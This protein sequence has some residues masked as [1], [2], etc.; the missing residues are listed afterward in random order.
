MKRGGGFT[1]I[2]L[3]VTLLI[4]TIVATLIL[5]SFRVG[6][7]SWQKGKDKLEVYQNMRVCLDWMSSKIRGAFISSRN[8]G[9]SFQAEGRRLD[10]VV[11]THEEGGLS[12]ISLWL[13][14]DLNL[15]LMREDSIFK[16]LKTSEG[17]ILAE[18]VK[19]LGFEYY[20]QE[21]ASWKGS[22]NSK[23]LRRLPRAVKIS[24]S[25]ILEGREEITLLPV[26]IPIEAG[27]AG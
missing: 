9:L 20:D 15:L 21:E 1:L 25:F 18:R 10:F 3:L 6:L 5:G 12:Q 19:S 11:Q 26:I 8:P 7:Q 17:V 23:K 14:E 27:G 2:E 22:W 13:D 24:L 4:V 16:N